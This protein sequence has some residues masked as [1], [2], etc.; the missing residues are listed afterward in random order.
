MTM[1]TLHLHCVISIVHL[2]ICYPGNLHF[3][4][5]S[6]EYN[7]EIVRLIEPFLYEYVSER[8]GSISAEHGIGLSKRKYVHYNKSAPAQ[9]LMWLM[10]QTLDPRGILNPYKTVPP[11][12]TN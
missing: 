11:P 4:C 2:C 10:K 8:R 5:T 9:E 3:N 6:S 7:A 1:Q 12:D